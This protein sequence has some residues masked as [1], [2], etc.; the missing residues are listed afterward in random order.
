[1]L[2]ASLR[3]PFLV[4]TSLSLGVSPP[5]PPQ[6]LG[7]SIHFTLFNVIQ[8]NRKPST[9]KGIFRQI[10]TMYIALEAAI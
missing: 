1:M 7:K 5:P 8:L 4:S 2:Q 6:P 9:T 3:G 10:I